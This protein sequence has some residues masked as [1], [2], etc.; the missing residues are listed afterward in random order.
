MDHPICLVQ[1]FFLKMKCSC[2]NKRSA[3]HVCKVVVG[4]SRCCCLPFY[5][6]N[7]PLLSTLMVPISFKAFWLAMFL[8]KLSHFIACFLSS[9][10]QIEEKRHSIVKKKNAMQKIHFKF[11]HRNVQRWDFKVARIQIL[12]QKE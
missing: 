4:S 1:P 2:I 9:E 12:W 7:M 10:H 3:S 11:Q 8:S 5:S 6:Y